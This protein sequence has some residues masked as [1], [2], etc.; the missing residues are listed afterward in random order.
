MTSYGP[1]NWNVV[2]AAAWNRAILTPG[3][4]ARRL[5]GLA[6]GLGVEV[7][8][9]IE[10]LEPPKVIHEGTMITASTSL[11]IVEMKTQGYD[12]MEKALN[13]GAKALH[14]LPETPVRA[15]GYNIR[16][17]CH[18][19]MHL[20][21]SEPLQLQLNALSD[22]NYEVVSHGLLHQIRFR[23][24]VI[25]L[26]AVTK[27]DVL[28][29]ELNFHRDSNKREDLIEW[30]EIPVKEVE[31]EVSKLTSALGITITESNNDQDG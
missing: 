6:Q 22:N 31:A 4:I 8:V 16:Y 30:L 19:S 17:H 26:K 28:E 20:D 23:E 24:G 25:N 21:H 13:I 18:S 1:V 14:E 10:G 3:G 7:L 11:L 2:V 15:A 29:L 5:F 9:P 12:G 27:V